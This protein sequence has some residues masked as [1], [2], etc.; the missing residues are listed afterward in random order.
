MLSE[1]ENE[2][3]A[4]F[5]G[6]NARAD[7]REFRTKR[8]ERNTMLKVARKFYDGLHPQSL[9]VRPGDQDPNI[10]INFCRKVVDNSVAWM[11]GDVERG[12][13]LKME[14][15]GQN[16]TSK[17]QKP[18]SQNAE[19]QIGEAA[20]GEEESEAELWLSQAWEANG[21]P[22]FFQKMGKR[23]GITGHGFVK[24]VP[25]DDDENDLAPYPML[26][27]LKPEMVSIL[28]N[29]NNTDAVAA[30]LVEW[31]EKRTL[32]SKG[33][34]VTVTV[35]QFI[36]RLGPEETPWV[37]GTLSS[38]GKGRSRWA[39][40]AEPE[41]WPYGWC[42]IVE[43]QNLPND[44]N[45]YGLSDLEDLPELNKAINMIATNINRILFI[46]GHPRTVGIGFNAGEVQD[47]A[48]DAFWTIDNKDA[49]V[50]TLEMQSDLKSSFAFMQFLAQSLF[51]IARDL[52]LG[53]LR[54]RIG[55]VTDF[56]LRVLANTALAKL[57]EKRTTYGK[58]INRINAIML[59]LGEF[60]AQETKLHWKDPLP[61]NAG[62]EAD[63]L[64]KEIGVKIV[65]RRTAIE[66]RGRDAEVEEERMQ[67]EAAAERNVGG[68]I[69][70]AFE[71]GK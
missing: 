67:E 4:A 60:P 17:T 55:Q 61:E 48:I 35:R 70:R 38:T 63:R 45:M 22:Q 71:E 34:A 12:L 47:T 36:A 5:W 21:G 41:V 15:I 54:D 8:N 49:K 33:K 16:Q 66:E 42:P 40:D 6:L 11:F 3:E 29:P 23:T 1:N 26:V 56:G 57:G 58:A 19:G 7:E 43:W 13:M 62:E 31:D 68:E 32:T 50:Q 24:V 30:Y 10:I 20:G 46:H 25:P 14:L 27:L 64:V 37:V 2:Y 53:S 44:N 69:L 51:D 65:S 39:F 18:K 59:E 52:D 9:K 28:P